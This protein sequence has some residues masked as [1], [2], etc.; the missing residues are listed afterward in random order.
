[1]RQNA[2]PMLEADGVDLVLAGHSHAYERSLL[3]DGHYGLSTTLQPAMIRDGGDGA[4]R[5]RR[6]LRQ[7]GRPAPHAGTVYVVAGSRAQLG[8]GTLNHPA[9]VRSLDVLGS[10]VLD[11]DGHALSGRFLTDTG[12]R[13]RRLHDHQGGGRNA[14]SPA[15]R[16]RYYRN[17]GAVPGVASPPAQSSDTGGGF[18]GGGADRRAAGAA[19]AA[20]RRP[21]AR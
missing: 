17:G 20:Q 15:A 5:G 16:S 3:L 1:M 11:V 7:A 21:A 14:R 12:R 9:M 2:L 8:G 19:A 10:L 13:A 6:R 4:R 18:C